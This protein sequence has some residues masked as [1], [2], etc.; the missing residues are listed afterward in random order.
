MAQPSFVTN[1]RPVKE[2]IK[3]SD[4]SQDLFF[5]L[6]NRR[7]V[8]EGIKTNDGVSRQRRVATN[9]RPV[10]EGIK[11]VLLLIADCDNDGPTED[12]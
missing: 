10:K 2:G 9:R 5:H 8:K 1:R 11:T 3:T 12:L 4:E 6:T 7:P